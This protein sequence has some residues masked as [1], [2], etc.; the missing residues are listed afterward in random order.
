MAI[1]GKGKRT[2][3]SGV[4]GAILLVVTFVGIEVLASYFVPAWPARAINTR[5]P[6]PTRT[7]AL[8]FRNQ[9]WLADP[10]NSWGL[11]D[12]ER[13]IAKQPFVRRV[14]FV[15]DSFVE[16]RFTPLS[17]PASVQ[18]RV[19]ARD[20]VEAVNLGVAAT[21]PRSYY[22]RIRDVGLELEPDAV[23][24]FIYAGNDFTTPG[25]GYSIWPRLLDESPG[26]ALVGN[27]MPRTNWLLVNRLRLSDF[28]RSR[29]GAPRSD[30]TVL[31]E[32]VTAPPTERLKRIVSYAK[33]YHYP[34]VPEEKLSEI[35]G[36]G[37]NRFIEIARPQPGPE[38]EY[39]LDWMFATLLSWETADFEVARSRA[40]AVRLMGTTQVDETFSW[41]EAIERLLRPRGIPL[42]V[43]LIPMG[44]VDPEYVDF[45]KPWPR[46][47][48]WN[49]ICDEWAAGLAAKL[50]KADIPLV[51]LRTA[52]EGVPG[53][54]RKMDG[55]WSQ[56]G[57]A[58]VADRVAAELEAL[59]LIQP[60]A[61]APPSRRLAPTE[62]P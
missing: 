42:V 18:Q 55:H 46:A 45:W 40:D 44:S 41:I 17:L 60:R 52:L 38:Q 21:D 51:N 24:L 54:Y 11:R 1:V 3:F 62:S 35:L 22:Y 28:F 8:P 23:L 43:F 14:L 26:G 20:R 10:D 49:F 61:T 2:L 6:A 5:E 58:I 39:L 7:L 4:F 13:T 53:T 33:T 48:S 25:N 30:E 19:P 32:A 56:K 59:L 12:L 36:R 15:G 27:V 50:T 37:D 31:F 34:N 47:Y 9:P 57:E 16:S 29:S